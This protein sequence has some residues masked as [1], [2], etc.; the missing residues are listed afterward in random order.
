MAWGHTTESERKD[1]ERSIE[2]LINIFDCV[3]I[4]DYEVGDPPSAC[5]SLLHDL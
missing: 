3:R 5:V 4:E 1:V 2:S